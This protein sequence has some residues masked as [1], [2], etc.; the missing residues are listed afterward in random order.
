LLFDRPQLHIPPG[1]LYTS[2]EKILL[3]YDEET[4]L[5]LLLTFVIA[6]ITV[7][8]IKSISKNISNLVF[9][10]T[11]QSPTLNIFQAFFGIGQTNLPKNNFGRIILTSFLLWCLVIRTAYQGKLFE[12]T[13]T[14]MRK[15]EMQ[16]LEELRLNN[17]TL[18]TSRH[19]YSHN[20]HLIAQNIIG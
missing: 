11:V 9:G 15:S 6:T 13:T 19:Q 12:F 18:Y 14:A 2:F 5:G 7:R 16:N 20:M 8:V 4:W 1:D 3:P 17:F 10:A